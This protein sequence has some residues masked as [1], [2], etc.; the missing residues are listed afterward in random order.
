M[1]PQD[2]ASPG[3]TRSRVGVYDRPARAGTPRWLIPAAIAVVV[4]GAV[5]IAA[6]VW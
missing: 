5:L 4:V 3:G 2:K 6:I 1:D